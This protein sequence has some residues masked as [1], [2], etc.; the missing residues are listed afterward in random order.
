MVRR[1][2]SKSVHPAHL[3]HAKL[4]GEMPMLALGEKFADPLYAALQEHGYGDLTGGDGQQ[5]EAGRVEWLGIDIRLVNLDD[6]LEFTRRTLQM[7]GAPPGSE[8]QYTI[9]GQT[10][11]RPIDDSPSV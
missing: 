1:A 5:D 6:A 9:D 11:T 8:L 3:V 4:L 7:L 10:C 2:I